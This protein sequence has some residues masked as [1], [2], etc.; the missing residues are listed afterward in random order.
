M[1][2]PSYRDVS[3]TTRR[4]DWKDLR[5]TADQFILANDASNSLA[6]RPLIKAQDAYT[7]LRQL[8]LSHAGHHSPLRLTVPVYV[9]QVTAVTLF[10]AALLLYTV[11]KTL[12]SYP[13]DAPELQYEV[14]HIIRGSAGSSPSIRTSSPHMSR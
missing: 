2:A 6:L 11:S 13:V 1:S 8:Q 5:R 3:G 4:F 12:A 10:Y 9:V 7:F 14:S